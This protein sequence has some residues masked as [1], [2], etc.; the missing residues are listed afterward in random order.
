V[1]D[2]DLADRIARQETAEEVRNLAAAYAD[3]CDAKDLEALR[4]ILAPDVV[5]S[6]P[7]R[8]WRGTDDVVSFYATAWAASPDR[9]RHFMTN[10][11]TRSL[12][13]DR[14]EATSYFLY[15]TTQ[16]GRSMVGWGAY[17]DTFVRRDGR[18]VFQSKHIDMDLLADLDEGWAKQFTGPPGT[19]PS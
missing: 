3:A 4:G 14:A 2:A 16:D 18:L 9:S 10:V 8:S 6:V 11:A 15:V 13:V 17:R 1:T 19:V 5:V 12:E 7:G